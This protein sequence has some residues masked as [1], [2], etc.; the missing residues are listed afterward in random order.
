MLEKLVLAEYCT[1]QLHGVI[2]VFESWFSTELASHETNSVS[3]ISCT[4]HSCFSDT[5]EEDQSIEGLDGL[6][7]T[8]KSNYTRFF[9]EMRKYGSNTVYLN[10]MKV[11]NMKRQWW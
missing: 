9:E 1:L 4:V 10:E 8:H 2:F 7:R 6:L 5:A 3:Q 11:T